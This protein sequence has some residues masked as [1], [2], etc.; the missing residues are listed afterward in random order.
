[1]VG[2]A[3]RSS[4]LLMPESEQFRPTAW[5]PVADVRRVETKWNPGSRGPFFDRRKFLI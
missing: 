4:E 3:I 2:A 5:G 1:V